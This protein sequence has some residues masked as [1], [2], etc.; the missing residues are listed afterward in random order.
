[1]IRPLA[2][3]LLLAAIGSAQSPDE[4]KQT[5][6]GLKAAFRTKD[7]VVIDKAI[8][9]SMKVNDPAVSKEI[10]K[11]LRDRSLAVREAAIEALGSM[12]NET[13]LK[14]LH[15]LYFGN[16]SLSKN[17]KLFALLLKEIGRHGDPSSIK[18][19]I[20]SP[21]NRL[22]LESGTAR[23]MGL[24][25]IRD[26]QSVEE[27]V[28]LSRK[29]SGKQRG[30]GVTS[31]WRGAFN[32]A[33]DDAMR[34][35]TGQE[36]G[37]G[38]EDLEKW[39]RANRKD[40]EVDPERPKVPD[41]VSKRWA[42]YWQKT[43][44]KDAKQAP[45]P[46][47]FNAPVII[48]ETPTPEQESQAVA[49]L[50]DAFKSKDADTI[51]NALQRY[52]GTVSSRVVHEVAR[53]LRYRDSKVRMIAVQALGWMP[54]A[55]ALKQLHRMYRREKKLGKDDEALFAE[56][57]KEIGRHGDKSSIKVL[58]DKPF[59]YHTLASS[60]ARIY[61]LGN[62]RVKDSV[63]TLMKG[64]Q[65]TGTGGTRDRRSFKQDQPRAM[66][67]FNVALTVLTGTSLGPN[68]QAWLQWWRDAKK[69][70]KVSPE[71]PKVP[72]EIRR[73]WEAYWNEQY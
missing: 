30:S 49:N 21:F 62:I 48:V 38:K 55:E 33:F 69:K 11:G 41:E 40:L 70:L 66:P 52:G 37:R 6:D 60:R 25:N 59:K 13:A 44:Y 67:E 64:M 8:R 58:S 73:K 50:K 29:S 3:L 20:D 2:V 72:D 10:A 28:K 51:A 47:T 42:S 34:I 68:Q 31:Q 24:G 5:V 32:Q 57:L 17:P 26:K 7:E 56:L 19:M 4:V 15:R 46:Q 39:W 9:Q 23:L 16:R 18:V 14:E 45:P 1:M 71:R 53:G 36:Y 35:L 27:L 65:K 63:E 54:S 61:G 22:T 12:D 43:Y